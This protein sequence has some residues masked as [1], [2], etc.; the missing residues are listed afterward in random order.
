MAELMTCPVCGKD[1]PAIEY[2]INEAGN[3]VCPDC[4]RNENEDKKTE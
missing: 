2:Q 1:F 4:F 3:P